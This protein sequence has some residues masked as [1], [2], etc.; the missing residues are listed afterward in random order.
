MVLITSPPSVSRLSRSM[1]ASTSHDLWASA[2]FYR[3]SL[4]FICTDVPLLTYHYYRRPCYSSTTT[5]TDTDL[6]LLRLLLQPLFLVMALTVIMIEA[7]LH[8]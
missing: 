4:T 5:T 3:D 8:V 1:G 7:L 2:T 6:L